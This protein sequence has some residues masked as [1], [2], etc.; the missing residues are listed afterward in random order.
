MLLISDANIL[1]DFDCCNLLAEVFQLPDDLAVP[2][3]LFIEELQQNHPEL[4]DLGLQIHSLSAESVDESVRLGG[5]YA[6]P[7]RND[8]F[9]LSLAK[10]LDCPLLTG[11]KRLRNAADSERVTYFGTLW[12]MERL[13]THGVIEVNQAEV[14]FNCMKNN[15]RRLP[16]RAVGQ[17]IR[18][19]KA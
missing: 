3:I 16:W 11:D 9:A 5:L 8:L 7:S 17:L 14:A 13:V 19:L 4:L 6:Q 1:I 15:Q 12:L 10:S 18:R 2:D